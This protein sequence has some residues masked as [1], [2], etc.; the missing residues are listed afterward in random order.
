MKI[1]LDLFAGAHRPPTKEDM[2]KNIGA[3]RRAIKGK[4]L[5][6]DNMWLRD[7]EFILKKIQEQIPE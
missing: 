3:V 7:T 1:T 4:K 2:E 5:A 6:I